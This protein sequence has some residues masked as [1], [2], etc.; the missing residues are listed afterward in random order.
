MSD[1]GDA[2][3]LDEFLDAAGLG[4]LASRDGSPDSAPST[5]KPTPKK[6]KNPPKSSSS[7]TKRRKRS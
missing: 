6:R 7:K 4:G 3:L 2:D 5:S 1:A